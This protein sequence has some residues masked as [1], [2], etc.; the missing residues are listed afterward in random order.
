MKK[1]ATIF[2]LLS[3]FSL[4]NLLAKP[5][6]FWISAEDIG[7]HF[8]CYGDPHAITPNIDKCLKGIVCERDPFDFISH[9]RPKHPLTHTIIYEMHVGAFTNGEDSKLSKNLQGTLKGLI[10]KILPVAD[11]AVEL[12]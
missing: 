1:I 6:I 9:P 3:L 5:N 8:G 7:R 4:S 2:F 11:Y 12:P 10:K